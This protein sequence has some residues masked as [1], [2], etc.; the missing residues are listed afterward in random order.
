MGVVRGGRRR[1]IMTPTM[2]VA[3]NTNQPQKTMTIM[4]TVDTAGKVGV[5]AGAVLGVTELIVGDAEIVSENIVGAFDGETVWNFAVVGVADP[6]RLERYNC[7]S[8]APIVIEL[9]DS[10]AS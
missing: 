6:S 9:F 7:F 5:F 4:V 1:S 3:S 10:E 8:L 2:I